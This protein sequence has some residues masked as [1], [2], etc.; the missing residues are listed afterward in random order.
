MHP[1][2]SWNLKKGIFQAWKVLENDCGHGKSWN[3]SNRSW[4]FLKEG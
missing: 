4:N 1:G 2:R 3:F